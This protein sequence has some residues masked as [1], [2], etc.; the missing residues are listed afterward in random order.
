M[1]QFTEIIMER[2]TLDGL[3]PLSGG[4]DFA[5]RDYQAGDDLAWRRIQAEADLHNAI[6]PDLFAREF[7][8][9][10]SQHANRILFAVTPTGEPVGTAAAWWGSSP[11]DW[12]GRVHW[13]AVRPAWQRK[14]IG[15]EL[16]VAA[17]SR[18]RDLGHG[19]AFL[20]T[21]PVRVEALRLY[22]SLGFL[23]RIADPNDRST[24]REIASRLG[25]KS[26]AE[27]LGGK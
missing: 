25:D 12:W 11:T 6:T 24:W 22:L 17:C 20:T 4:A 14:G 5:V 15:R 3:P 1:L 21:S 27:W 23:P 18:L 10:A 8:D 19:A 16:L 26:L 2:P 9:V 7:G 13:V